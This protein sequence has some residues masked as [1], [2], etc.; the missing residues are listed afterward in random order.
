M[1]KLQQAPGSGCTR[2]ALLGFGLF[3]TGLTCVIAAPVVIFDLIEVDRLPVLLENPSRLV[4][5]LAGAA[6]PLL[7]VG[8]FLSVGLACIILGLKPLLAGTRIAPPEVGVSNSTLRSGEAFTLTYQQL[9]KN[10]VDVEQITLQLVLRESATY[11]R[12][13]DSVT[14]VYDH[15]IQS[16]ETPARRFEAG[17]TF[18]ER[19]ELAIPRGAMHSFE[20]SRNRLRW[21]IKAK[22]KLKGWPDF[23]EEYALRVLPELTR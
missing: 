5:V 12:G 19:R 21:L 4:G 22:V 17:E 7:F 2:Y 6:G 9:F 8:C 3:W 15:L 1:Q 16:F 10:A 18:N 11:R 13:T 23:D 20:A 14:V